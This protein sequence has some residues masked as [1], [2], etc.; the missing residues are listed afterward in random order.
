[1]STKPAD[2]IGWIDAARGLS[3]LA[4]VLFHV[5]IWVY[6]PGA[7]QHSNPIQKLWER[8]GE[9]LGS[10]RIPLLLLLSGMLV[11]KKIRN[12][13][14]DPKLRYSIATNYYFYALWLL[15]YFL[16]FIVIQI[17]VPH[18]FHS[19]GQLVRQLFIPDTTLWYIFALVVYTVVLGLL[20]TV[21]VAVVLPVSVLGSIAVVVSPLD[22]LWTKIPE[23]MMFF[24][25]GVYG[26]RLLFSAAS[27][28]RWWH[29]VLLC[30]TAV[31]A[32]YTAGRVPWEILAVSLRLVFKVASAALGLWVVIF[33][34]RSRAISKP[35]SALGRRTLP[36]YVLHAPMLYLWLWASETL[37]T[38][39]YLSSTGS[40]AWNVLFP[41]SLTTAVVAAS[42]LLFTVFTKCGLN[43]LFEA[44]FRPGTKNHRA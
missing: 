13:S 35:L 8:Q 5:V 23:N 27:W 19:V 16:I 10:I 18:A 39:A 41:V 9:I 14:G 25:L 42:L 38:D 17:Q 44:P 30:V 22:G 34:C 15:V 29:P 33:I 37:W 2:R 43:F 12:G 3:V 32:L 20:R 24:V 26:S 1:M 28:V 4:I 40:T 7:G 11:S 31:C 36:I 6:L 21:P